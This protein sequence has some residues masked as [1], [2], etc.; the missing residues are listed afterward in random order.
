MRAGRVPTHSSQMTFFPTGAL[1]AATTVPIQSI[2]QR[3][4]HEAPCNLPLLAWN[5]IYRSA[6]RFW[7]F[8]LARYR[9]EPYPIPVAIQGGISGAAGGL[10]EICA[11]SLF[12]NK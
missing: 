12:R 11:Q 5:P 4:I 10:A 3:L 1:A 2:W 8:D 9:L 6:L 7:V